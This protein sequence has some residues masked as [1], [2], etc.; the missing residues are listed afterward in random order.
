[1]TK[2]DD[3]IKTNLTC[4][5]D[6]ITISG[7]FTTLVP[8]TTIITDIKN[9]IDTMSVEEEIRNNNPIV[10]EAYEQYQMLLKT[11]Q[12]EEIDK[13]FEKRY[14]VKDGKME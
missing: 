13:N 3:I 9:Y 12:D 2:K 4:K 14:G 1:M 6:Y 8:N 5:S 11:C 7:T 10:K